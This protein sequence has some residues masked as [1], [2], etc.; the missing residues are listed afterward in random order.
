M[1]IESIW[2]VKGRGNIV[3]VTL[4]DTLDRVCPAGPHE[5][6]IGPHDLR[7]VFKARSVLY[8]TVDA[9][10]A[11]VRGVEAF[12][13][14]GGPGPGETIGLLLDPEVPCEVGSVVEWV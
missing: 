9:R 6:R 1:R 10:S 7:E 5:W 2:P 8:V 4:D 12:C 13:K 14:L 11:A 3:T